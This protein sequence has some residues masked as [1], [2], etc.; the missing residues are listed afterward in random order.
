[1]LA[2]R[3][4]GVH[5]HAGSAAFWHIALSASEARSHVLLPLDDVQRL[6]PDVAAQSGRVAVARLGA[7]GDAILRHFVVLEDGSAVPAQ[8]A[9]ARVLSSGLLEVQ[10][11]HRLA[12]GGGSVTLRATFHELTD[13]THRVIAR[14]EDVRRDATERRRDGA[15]TLMFDVAAS[16]HVVTSEPLASWRD[17]GAPAGSTR[18]MILLGIEHILTGYDHLVFLACLLIAGGTWWSRAGII[19][20][21]TLAHSVTL[22]LAALRVV[23]PPERFV[24]A[25]IAV[26][27]AY[28]AIENLVADPRRARWPAAFGFG[29]VHG[30]GFA[31][32]LDGLE[33]PAGQWLAAV[34][35]FNVGVELGQLVAM[36]VSLP[37][38]NLL[39]RSSWHAHVVRY[40]SS[41]VLG[42][43]V[44]WLLERLS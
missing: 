24:E 35:T 41:A 28:V 27:I 37:I 17:V 9:D 42:L 26:S 6:A 20:A 21:F 14:V 22:V 16:E 25:A 1:M 5:A 29:L 43:A 2:A 36:A 12:P 8:V 32:M 11:R 10:L 7:F 19:S 23:T 34:L 38:I 33:L 31:G 30:L 44:F 3:P 15:A 18:A 40:G 4:H 39:T 13:D